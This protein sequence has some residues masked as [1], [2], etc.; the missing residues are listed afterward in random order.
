MT[1]RPEWVDRVAVVTRDDA[2]ADIVA[3]VHPLA[4]VLAAAAELKPGQAYLLVT[5][6]PP[7]PLLDKAR[8]LGLHVWTEAVGTGEVRSLIA[9]AED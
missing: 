7:A 4:R 2:R 5:P 9:R 3:G 1:E 6:F 8:A